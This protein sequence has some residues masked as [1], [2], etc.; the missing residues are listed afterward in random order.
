NNGMS[1]NLNYAGTYDKGLT[2]RPLL[3][4]FSD[5]DGDNDL[6]IITGGTEVAWFENLDGKGTYVFRRFLTNSIGADDIIM[7]DFDSDQDI[8]IIFVSKINDYIAWIPNLDGKA[9]FGEAQIIIRPAAISPTAIKSIDMDKDNHLDLLAVGSGTA[10]WIEKN[11][12]DYNTSVINLALSDPIR[13][14]VADLNKD[15]K[16]DFVVSF[17]Y[18]EQVRAYINEATTALPS[19]LDNAQFVVAPNPFNQFLTIRNKNHNLYSNWEISL[20]DALGRNTLLHQNIKDLNEF[21][22]NTN[23]LKNGIYFLKIKSSKGVDYHT[24]KLI[25]N[26]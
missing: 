25:K 18:N 11:G 1:F 6:D 20:I 10:L 22:I 14:E 7:L 17:L 5:I 13:L 12:I 15:G 8:D 9:N 4:K 23:H 19:I 2:N 24:V 3:V 21:T 26:K 16:D